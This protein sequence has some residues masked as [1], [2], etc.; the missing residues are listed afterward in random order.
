MK[1]YVTFYN[2]IFP[3]WLILFFPPVILLTIIGNYIIDSLV[4]VGCYKVYRLQDKDIN[5][6]PFYKEHIL[7][8]VVYGFLADIIGV[9]LLLV[10]TWS[11][12]FGLSNEIVSAISYNAFSHPMAFIIVLL[13]VLISFIFIFIFNYK[14][15]FDKSIMDKALRIK[16]A[17][18]IAIVTIPWTF[19]VPME[20][21]Y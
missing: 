6:K 11:D 20:W 3:F 13:A 15:V 19:F 9:A 1:R 2:L 18:S 10:C 12:L 14:K 17:I 7:S 4:L 21:F 8:V 16:I 5:L